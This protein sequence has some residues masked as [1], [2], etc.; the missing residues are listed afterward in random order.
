MEILEND[1]QILD[2]IMKESIHGEVILIGFPYDIGAKRNNQFHGQSNGPDCFRRFLSKT[3]SIYNPELDIDISELKI[4]DY[5]NIAIKTEKKLLTLEEIIEK[6]SQKIKIIINK[7]GVPFVVG[8]TK[9][10]IYGCL[11]GIKGQENG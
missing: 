11:Q 3:S 9:D 6:L 5:G 7:G 1:D 8:G 10:Q 2:T 4:R